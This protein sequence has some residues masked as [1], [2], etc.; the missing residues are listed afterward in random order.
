MAFLNEIYFHLGGEPVTGLRLLAVLVILLAGTGALLW[1]AT[2]LKRRIFWP[3][4]DGPE[5][6]RLI[7]HSARVK[8]LVITVLAALAA[9]GLDIMNI[10]WILLVLGG[11]TALALRDLI[12]ELWSGVLLLWEHPFSVGDKIA[13]GEFTGEVENVGLRATRIRSEDGLE[14]AVP[15]AFMLKHPLIN[16]S[17]TDGAVR[18]RIPLEVAVGSDSSDVI[19]ILRKVAERNSRIRKSP[20]PKVFLTGFGSRGLRFDMLAWVDNHSEEIWATNELCRAIES[21]LRR[22]GISLAVAGVETG[23]GGP[24][25]SGPS[26][27]RT[28]STPRRPRASERTRSSPEHASAT[29]VVQA[30]PDDTHRES[31]PPASTAAPAAAEQELTPQAPAVQSEP[32][33]K[34]PAGSDEGEKRTRQ[35]PTSTPATYGRSKRRTIR[36]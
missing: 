15:N 27:T 8:I 30:T 31:P 35:E 6:A 34:L 25:K 26:R 4:T 36:R 22:S 14:V 33:A 28:T 13:A 29:P 17:R 19:T 11:L 18:V 32:V 1:S 24:P 12:T 9:L 2:T 23:S 16:R 21:E 10:I 20:S 3:G 5:G 7:L